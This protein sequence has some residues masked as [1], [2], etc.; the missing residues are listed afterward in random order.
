MTFHRVETIMSRKRVRFMLDVVKRAA[1]SIQVVFV[2]HDATAKKLIDFGLLDEFVSIGKVIPRPLQSH[3]DFVN[4]V[5]KAAF[6][7]TDG[8]SI[9]E[10]CAYLGKPC[11][12][13]RS[14][15]ERLEGLDSVVRMSN[16]DWTEV[17]SFLNSYKNL[18]LVARTPNLR[19]AEEV[20]EVLIELFGRGEPIQ[21]KP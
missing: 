17:A 8:G 3:A 10:D 15:T 1:E 9:Q 2:Q 18:G 12:V 19:S 6:V 21:A 16:F 5:D 13:M 4:L 20:F 11:L 7:I 14:E